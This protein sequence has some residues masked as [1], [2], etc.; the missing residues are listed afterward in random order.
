VKIYP[1]NLFRIFLNFN[2]F[3]LCSILFAGILLCLMLCP[4]KATSGSYLDSAHGNNQGSDTGYGVKRNATGF[5]SD[6]ARGNCAHCHEQHASIG[7]AEP[8][9]TGGPDKY[10]LLSNN[11]DTSATANPYAQ[12]DDVCF[13]CHTTSIATLQSS[14]FN[15]YTYSITFGG[16][17]DTTPNNIFDTFNSTS[18]H[19]LY[20]IFRLITGLYGS[21]SFS[22]FPADSNPCSGCH[23]VHIAKKSCGKPSG[24]YDPTKSA[25]S[26]PSDHNNL[27]GDDTS[28]RMNVYTSLYQAPYWYGST[29]DYEPD[30]STTIDG[31]NLVDYVTFCTDCHDNSNTIGSTTLG[32]NLKT[33]NWDIEKHGKGVS[34]GTN[35]YCT[36]TTGFLS[37]YPTACTAT[38][39][40]LTCDPNGCDPPTCSPRPS[41]GCCSSSADCS[42]PNIVL[43]CTDC[44][45]PHGAPN[46]VL[47][48]KEVNGGTLSGQITTLPTTGTGNSELGYLCARCHTEDTP[49][50][51]NWG[52]VHHNE[53][54]AF[55]CNGTGVMCHGIVP[56]DFLSSTCSYCHYHG[57]VVTDTNG[58]KRTF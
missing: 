21:K 38:C 7:G 31:S 37:P 9:P 33:I 43:A 32:R 22:S 18:Y 14:A 17:P 3:Y 41:L 40:T 5:P 30:D 53:Y 34:D 12:S 25:I 13:Y 27:W 54:I 6:Y 46:V 10:C 26:K 15:N 8:A 29:T 1:K 42:S 35:C 19:N 57:S 2:L 4:E 49:G 44:H 23:N 36:N 47:I 39:T 51:N 58:S 50:S 16:N 24:S 45:E 20:D 52:S 11:F 48:R 56:G 28:E 55:G